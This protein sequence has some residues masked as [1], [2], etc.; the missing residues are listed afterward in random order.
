MKHEWTE[1]CV[2]LFVWLNISW[3]NDQ[4]SSVICRYIFCI[5]F[6]QYKC[7]IS[8]CFLLLVCF[9]NK[10]F[11]SKHYIKRFELKKNGPGC[12]V[13]WH[14]LSELC[15]FVCV[16]GIWDFKTWICTV[17]ARSCNPQPAT[18]PTGMHSLKWT[19]IELITHTH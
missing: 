11:L 15:G 18:N 17:R 9:F 13:M 2:W 1:M 19:H 14:V 12:Y 5:R 3:L 16:C 8:N 6:R 10:Q 7:K 4:K